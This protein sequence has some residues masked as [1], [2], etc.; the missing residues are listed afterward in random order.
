MVRPLTLMRTALLAGLCLLITITVQHYMGDRTI[1]SLQLLPDRLEAHEMILRN[2][3]VGAASWSARGSNG[4]NVRVATVWAAEQ[5]SARLGIDVPSIYKLIDIVSLFATLL[6]LFFFLRRW[7]ADAYC[8]LA[9]MFVGCVLPL[10]LLLH[11]FHPWD[12]PSLLVWLLAIWAIRD[13]RL[14][15]ATLLMG[16]AV[17]IKYDAVLLP[18]LYFLY[19]VGRAP[20]WRT[21]IATGL[22]SAVT[23]GTFL[24]LRFLIPGGFEPRV[25]STQVLK[26]L[27]VIANLAQPH[28]EILGLSLPI[29][30]ALIGFARGDRFMRAATLFGLALLIPFF[31]TTN[32]AEIRAHTPILVLLLPAA[33]VGLQAVLQPVVAKVPA[34]S[35]AAAQFSWGDLGM[36]RARGSR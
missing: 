28:P 4:T 22:M 10:T 20:W 17:V 12:R 5:L 18:G 2:E 34:A 1:Y 35:P 27:E 32:F 15:A 16:L 6:L 30:L 13:E 26:N 31:L 7:F 3:L 11:S 21:V 8:V 33:L 9:L 29:A 25:I 19:R 23:F 36:A 24:T 14:F